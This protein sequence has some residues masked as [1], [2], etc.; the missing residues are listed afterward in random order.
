MN[1]SAEAVLGSIAIIEGG[2]YF[3]MTVQKPAYQLTEKLRHTTTQT[4]S[5][6]FLTAEA[7][8]RSQGIPYSICG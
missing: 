6:R 3:K 2:Q 5:R 8:I 7:G 4:F 1:C